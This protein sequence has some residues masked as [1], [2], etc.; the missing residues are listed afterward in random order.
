MNKSK[1]LKK[2]LGMITA[3]IDFYSSKNILLDTIWRFPLNAWELIRSEIDKMNSN[4]TFDGQKYFG[5]MS[6]WTLLA[7][8][9]GDHFEDKNIPLITIYV[10]DTDKT[11]AAIESI[12]QI[13]NKEQTTTSKEN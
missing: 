5:E 8:H 11:K 1:D 10:D 6:W 13:L 12:R 7:K 2:A 9:G 4:F 3:D